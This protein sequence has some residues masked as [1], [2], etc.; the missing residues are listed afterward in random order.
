MNPLDMNPVEYDD[1]KHYKAWIRPRGD[2]D[3]RLELLRM[4]KRMADDPL[5]MEIIDIVMASE[6]DLSQQDIA[7]RIG[8]PQ[9]AISRT[10]QKM[11]KRHT[12]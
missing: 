11:R 12:V 5:A 9:Q 3:A 8:R 4:K 6:N 7:N 10:I 1:N 2:S